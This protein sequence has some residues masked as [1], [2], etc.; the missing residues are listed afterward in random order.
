M[1][2]IEYLRSF[3]LGEYAIFDI[4]SA[5]IGIYFLAPFL[6]YLFKFIKLDISLLSWL[7]LTIPLSIL[8]HILFGRLTPMTRYFLDPSSHYLL[9][10]FILALVLLGLSRIKILK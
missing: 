9:K 5:F 3:K 7:Y 10:L 8:V 1:F 6:T 4:A 2:S